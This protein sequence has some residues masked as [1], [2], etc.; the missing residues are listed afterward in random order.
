MQ[1]QTTRSKA[2]FTRDN[3]KGNTI[4]I[5]FWNRK[6]TRE[7]TV[8]FTL[9]LRGRFCSVIYHTFNLRSKSQYKQSHVQCAINWNWNAQPRYYVITTQVSAELGVTRRAGCEK[10]SWVRRAGCDKTSWVRRAGCEKTSWVWQDELG[11]K[12]RAG[13]DKTSDVRVT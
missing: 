9:E 10:T 3:I 7:I 13:C 4:Y 2:L 8:K 5:K 12:R 6:R 1:W 11:V